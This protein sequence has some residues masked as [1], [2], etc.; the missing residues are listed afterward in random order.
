[1]SNIQ[2]Q[3]VD[4]GANLL[5]S[6]FRGQYHGTQKHPDDF[7]DIITRARNVGVNACLVTAGCVSEAVDGIA[8]SEH[9]PDNMTFATTVGVH[10]CRVKDV[11]HDRHHSNLSI[12][13]HSVTQDEWDVMVMQEMLRLADSNH[14]RAIGEFGLDYDRL[15]FTPKELQQKYF[16]FQFKMLDTCHKPLF[17]H[18]RAADDEFI[19]AMRENR[20]RFTN[21]VVHSFDGSL[22][23]LNALL[24]LGLYIG[25]NGCSLRDASAH[26]V[27]KHIPLDRIMIETDCP[28]C[29]IKPTHASFKHV[30]TT[31]PTTKK[32]VSGSCLKDRSEPCHIV[33]V[34]EALSAI[35]N[36]SLDDL[37]RNAYD[38]SMRVF[39]Q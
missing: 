4:I 13:R 15:F 7:D 2:H 18:C 5:D 22:D 34:A 11:F 27:V 37:T 20:H 26:E 24:S 38:N 25:I 21:G 28:Y 19:A 30:K 16:A 12:D 9:A 39:F 35:M 31:F 32:F 8:L 36:V 6:C 10:P 1:M 33:Q 17:L 3:Y 29:G 23:S 14:V